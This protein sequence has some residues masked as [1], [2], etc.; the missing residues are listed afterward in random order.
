[1]ELVGHLFRLFIV[2]HH[3]LLWVILHLN[4]YKSQKRYRGRFLVSSNF[5]YENFFRNTYK[6]VP[7]LNWTSRLT[8]IWIFS[9]SL[10]LIHEKTNFLLW[11]NTTSGALNTLIHGNATCMHFGYYDD[12][13]IL[14]FISVCR[15]VWGRACTKSG[16]R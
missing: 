8:C 1:M 3:W 14:S 11:W 4:G 5:F 15:G 16:Q 13:V 6:G 9:I 2:T 7:F 12:M 10:Y